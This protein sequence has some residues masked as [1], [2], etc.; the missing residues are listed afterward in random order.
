MIFN[1]VFSVSGREGSNGS[2][3]FMM[4]SGGQDGYSFYPRWN[5]ETAMLGSFDQR[6]KLFV[7]SKK[8]EEILVW[9]ST[10]LQFETT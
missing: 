10:S 7:S 4:S 2:V 3:S 6:V 1:T 5:E 8:K 9:S